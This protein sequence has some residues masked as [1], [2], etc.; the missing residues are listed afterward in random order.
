[1]IFLCLSWFVCRRESER[2]NH[3]L[4]RH[5]DILAAVETRL[6]LLNMTFMKYVDSNL[7]CFIPGKVGLKKKML[8]FLFC[9]LY[10]GSVTV[11]I[12][13]IKA[14]K[15]TKWDF[16]EG[17]WNGCPVVSI[18]APGFFR[19]LLSGEKNPVLMQ[20]A[21]S[22]F[23]S[24]YFSHLFQCTD[25][26]VLCFCS[27]NRWNIPRAALC[28]L[29]S[30]SPAGS[31]GSAGV[32]GHLLNGHGVFWWEDCPHSEEEAARSRSLWSPHQLSS[33]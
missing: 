27:G 18:Q 1:M 8:F 23:H 21:I 30:S 11:F 12:S 33:R 28:E 32:E 29:H 19:T 20:R 15:W 2:R 3:S 17:S 25:H 13:E 6:S 26:L 10:S 24:L 9:F 22:Y 5:A 7:C 4:A 31:R 14:I 16:E